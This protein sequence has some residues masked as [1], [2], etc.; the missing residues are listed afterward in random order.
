MACGISEFLPRITY[1]GSL[2]HIDPQTRTILQ[3]EL[4][5]RYGKYFHW[6]AKKQGKNKEPECAPSPPQLKVGDTL[7]GFQQ[8]PLN[9]GDDGK[10]RQSKVLVGK[11]IGAHHHATGSQSKVDR[12]YTPRLRRLVREIYR[13]DYQLWELIRDEKDVVSGSDLAVKISDECRDAASRLANV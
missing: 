1:V 2:N 4:W 9:L 8:R 10:T 7:Y 6:T 3:G 11:S 5:E 12:F 13:R